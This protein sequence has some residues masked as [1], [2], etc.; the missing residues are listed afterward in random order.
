MYEHPNE[1]MPVRMASLSTGIA[2]PA[3][4]PVNANQQPGV[5]PPRE[6]YIPVKFT[7]YP[8]FVVVWPV[9]LLG[10]LFALLHTV[11]P[12]SYPERFASTLWLMAMFAVME[13]LS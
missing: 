10:F 12:E 9:I 5:D 11:V 6:E 3:A 8:N 2:Q 4:T 7:A 1:P 13:N